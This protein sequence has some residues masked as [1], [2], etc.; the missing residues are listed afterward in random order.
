MTEEDRLFHLACAHVVSKPG[1]TFSKATQKA[2][3]DLKI[4]SYTAIKQ[5]EL[6]YQQEKQEAKYQLDQKATKRRGVHAR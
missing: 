3:E 1:W 4:K 6:N 5:Q 2:K